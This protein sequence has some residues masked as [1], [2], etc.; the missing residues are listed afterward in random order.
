MIETLLALIAGGTVGVAARWAVS[1]SALA[2]LGGWLPWGTFAVNLS[3]CLLIGFFDAAAAKRGFGGPHGR[4]LLM[5]GFCGGY[6]TFS[7]LILELD[8][9]LRAAPLRGA[10]YLVAS[11]A[12]GLALFRAGAFLGG[13]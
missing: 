2:F 7:S 3:G 10:G 9:L 13:R 11:V 5:T 1:V 4:M 8:S 12:A 6:T